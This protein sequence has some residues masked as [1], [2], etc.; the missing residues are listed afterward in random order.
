MSKL[1]LRL[2]A[3]MRAVVDAELIFGAD[4]VQ[5]RRQLATMARLQA[6]HAR[7]S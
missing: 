1:E 2:T 7:A 5:H 3:A 4:S 6:R